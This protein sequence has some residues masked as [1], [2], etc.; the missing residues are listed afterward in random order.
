MRTGAGKYDAANPAVVNMK[1][2]VTIKEIDQVKAIADPLRLQ[3]LEAFCRKP[4]TTRQV[5]LLLEVNPTRLYHHVDLLERSGLIELVRTQKNRGTTEKYY[6]G[7]AKKFAV[8]ARLFD[9]GNAGE[10]PRLLHDVFTMTLEV[11]LAE[12]R[13]SIQDKLI[14][15]D[16]ESSNATVARAQ[17]VT[18]S[19]NAELLVKKVQEWIGEAREL[20]DPD[21]DLRYGLTIAFYPVKKV[22][23]SKRIIKELVV[24]P[25]KRKA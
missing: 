7:V 13:K 6:Q 18:S 15:Q 16:R 19:E 8:D 10:T 21:G 25:A 2:S 3:I 22:Q 4:M 24:R 5:A 9:V 14:S 12:I 23:K 1:E 20:A 11:A 17:I